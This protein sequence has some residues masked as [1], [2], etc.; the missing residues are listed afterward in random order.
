MQNQWKGSDFIYLFIYISFLL[1]LQL[2]SQMMIVKSVKEYSWKP[3]DAKH[4]NG[5][6][7]HLKIANVGEKQRLTISDFKS[8]LPS[9]YYSFLALII[10]SVFPEVMFIKAWY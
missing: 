3:E 2:I 6:R 4:R 8:F 1:F 7:K 5:V 9:H 10:T